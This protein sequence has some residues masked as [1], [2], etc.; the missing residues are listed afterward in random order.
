MFIHSVV[1]RYCKLEFFLSFYK[2]F[3]LLFKIFGAL[4]Q[5]ILLLVM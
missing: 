1:Y 5:E 2:F 3:N 4:L